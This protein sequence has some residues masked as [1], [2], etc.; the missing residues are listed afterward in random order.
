MS[1]LIYDGGNKMKKGL[2]ILCAALSLTA[3]MS[4]SAFAAETKKEYRAEAEPIRTEMK[5]MEEQMVSV[6]VPISV[7]K[8]TFPLFLYL[9]K[10]RRSTVLWE[11]LSEAMTIL[12]SPFFH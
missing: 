7:V 5:V 12:Q 10:I 8:A 2:K 6:Y 11:S 9:P 3:I 4:F 1:K